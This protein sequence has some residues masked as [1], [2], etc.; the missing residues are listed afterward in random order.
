[1]AAQSSIHW[2]DIFLPDVP[3]MEI[4]I[5]GTLVYLFIFFLLRFILKRQAGTVGITDLLVVVLIA[6]ASQNAMAAD[7]QS[8]PAGLF[9]V[10][11]IIFWSYTLDW[12]G[13]RFPRMQRLVHPPP[14][15]LIQNGR[16]L[17]RNLRKELITEG[18]LMTQLREQGI[19]DIQAVKLAFMEGNGMISVIPYENNTAQQKPQRPGH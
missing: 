15:P 13:Y 18:E 17:Y 14:L 7:Y 10:G 8:V 1:M 11:T 2:Q 9:L 16:L 19:I 6:D 3:L 5:R 4:F 12:L